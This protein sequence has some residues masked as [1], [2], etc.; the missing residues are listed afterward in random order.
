MHFSAHLLPIPEPNQ[1][2]S[3]FGQRPKRGVRMTNLVAA[4]VRAVSL[5]VFSPIRPAEGPSC[6]RATGLE[7][8]K[9]LPIL[10]AASRSLRNRQRGHRALLVRRIPRKARQRNVEFFGLDVM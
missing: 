7:G 5:G 8:G 9:G 2:N 6:A 1:A 3:A 10:S 4:P